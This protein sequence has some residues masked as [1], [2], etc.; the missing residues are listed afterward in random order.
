M[1]TDS[2]T[3]EPSQVAKTGPDE[4]DHWSQMSFFLSLS[5]KPASR[6]CKSGPKIPEM[7]QCELIGFIV[8]QTQSLVVA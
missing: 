6:P 2:V 4:Y 1:I 5:H 7:Q 3:F 8:H